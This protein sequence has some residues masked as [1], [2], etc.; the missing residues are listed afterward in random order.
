[1]GT[2]SQFAGEADELA[3]LDEADEPDE[4]DELLELLEASDVPV[5]DPAELVP[6]ES[7]DVD[8]ER[9]SVR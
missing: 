7:D 6:D 1:M 9:L 8:V 5:D 2:G 4:L 3:V